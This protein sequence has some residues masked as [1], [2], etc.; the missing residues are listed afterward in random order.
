MPGET[1]YQPVMGGQEY[2][3]L[4]QNVNPLGTGAATDI[5]NQLQRS[6]MGSAPAEVGD[7][8]N[9]MNAFLGAAPQLQGLAQGATSDL[10][11]ALLSQQQAFLQPAL[12][13]AASTA[14]NMNAYNSSFAQQLMAR[15][16]AKYA[17]QNAAQAQQGLL[18]TTQGLW[19]QAL[20]AFAQAR[21]QDISMR[22]QDISR[23]QNIYNL[24]AGMS[25]PNMVA[26]DI[27][28]EYTPGAW[29]YISQLLGAG[30]Q[31]GTAALLGG[32]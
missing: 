27:A 25:T 23:Q 19:G 10:Q 12:A 29:D 4:F 17:M 24:L 32:G 18:G 30:T 20:P 7:M 1:S 31:L 21:G 13:Q 6:A 15:E 28:T 9:F 5:F 8:G 11:S 14:S 22:G 16:A 2:A 26:P 3:A